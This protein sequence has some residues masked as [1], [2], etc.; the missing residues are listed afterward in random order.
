MISSLIIHLIAVVI[1]YL[2]GNYTY[3]G[4]FKESKLEYPFGAKVIVILT[5]ATGILGLAA[6]LVILLPYLIFRNPKW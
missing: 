4:M 3:R 6:W 5:A 2:I 1:A